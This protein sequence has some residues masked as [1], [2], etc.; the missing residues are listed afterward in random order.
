MRNEIL[1]KIVPCLWSLLLSPT[2]L[3]ALQSQVR[4]DIGL[5]SRRGKGILSAQI[6][7]IEQVYKRKVVVSL[8]KTLALG[9]KVE[10]EDI[11]QYLD[12]RFG[13]SEEAILI[14]ML[15]ESGLIAIRVGEDL[16][17]RR[18]FSDADQDRLVKI[19]ESN[20]V[21]KFYD[22]G[23]VEALAFITSTF[24]NYTEGTQIP[25]EFGGP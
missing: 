1:R 19:L 14:L 24:M 7:L 3:V 15:A 22:K 16:S 9:R 6:A 20:F 11:L 5:L 8:V 2:L 18:Q 13:R 10:Q 4:D 17:K 12:R 25:R 21:K 23:V